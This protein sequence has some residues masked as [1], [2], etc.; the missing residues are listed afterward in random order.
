M[1]PFPKSDVTFN[2]GL[3]ACSY[4]EMWTK[5]K[6]PVGGD[7]PVTCPCCIPAFHW[8][9]PLKVALAWKD[10]LDAVSTASSS[11]AA[12]GPMGYILQIAADIS[13]ESLVSLEQVLPM[14]QCLQTALQTFSSE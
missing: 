14:F 7:D 10:S 9:W 3:P 11:P 13:S 8:S 6:N 2:R 12:P 1:R 4:N 5:E